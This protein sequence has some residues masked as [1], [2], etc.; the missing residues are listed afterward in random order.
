M[1]AERGG[2]GA[3]VGVAGQGHVRVEAFPCV[4]PVMAGRRSGGAVAEHEGGFVV[5]GSAG[6]PPGYVVDGQIALDDAVGQKS[7]S[8]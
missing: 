5:A 2:G 4:V 6:W 3:V 8:Q 7:C 1:A